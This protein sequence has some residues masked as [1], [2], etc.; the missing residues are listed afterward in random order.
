M[1][2]HPKPQRKSIVRSTRNGRPKRTNQP[3]LPVHVGFGQAPDDGGGFMTLLLE[4]IGWAELNGLKQR[5]HGAGR[6]E[7][8]LSRGQLL[9]ALLFHYTVSWAGSFAE[10]LFCLLGIQMAEST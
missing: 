6:P 8:V 9:A 1:R 10:H 4:R 7:Y 2:T 5:K 3:K